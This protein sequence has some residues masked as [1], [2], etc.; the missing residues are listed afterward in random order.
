[1]FWKI[2]NMTDFFHVHLQPS[3]VFFELCEQVMLSDL[4]VKTASAIK[5]SALLYDVV[6]GENIPIHAAPTLQHI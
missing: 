2:E 6:T 3:S 4:P 5:P 1:M